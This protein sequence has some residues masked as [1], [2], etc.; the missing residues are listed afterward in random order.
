MRSDWQ[1]TSLRGTSS[2]DKQVTTGKPYSFTRVATWKWVLQVPP[3]V[4]NI[5]AASIHRTVQLVQTC[6]FTRSSTSRP[7]VL[8]L[9]KLIISPPG[10]YTVFKVPQVQM[11]HHQRS[12][13][14]T[15][16]SDTLTQLTSNPSSYSLHAC[17][18]SSIPSSQF[19]RREIP[20]SAVLYAIT[21]TNS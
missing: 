6:F 13:L 14:E 5:S 11:Y 2:F 10:Q 18:T 20:W 8:G 19:H 9:W 3:T 21:L 1:V 7:M 12:L 17:C 4:N 16:S 15:V